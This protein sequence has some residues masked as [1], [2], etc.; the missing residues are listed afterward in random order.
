MRANWR[1]RKGYKGRR[2]VELKGHRMRGKGE[3]EDYSKGRGRGRG[4][5]R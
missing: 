1:E 5:K 2:V 4:G 3:K